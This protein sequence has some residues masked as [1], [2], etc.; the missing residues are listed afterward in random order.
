MSIHA[1]FYLVQQHDLSIKL[2]A[3]LHAQLP[4]TANAGAQLVKMVVLISKYLAMVLVNLLVVEVRLIGRGIGVWVVAVREER[5]TVGV[6][7]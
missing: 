5:G 7:W 3:N 6:L 2:V 1:L 4:L